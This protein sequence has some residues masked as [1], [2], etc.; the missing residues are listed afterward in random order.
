MENLVTYEGDFTDNAPGGYGKLI[1]P[2][3]CY[4]EGQITFTDA[5]FTIEGK[6]VN[7]LGGVRTGT[8]T[9]D[10]TEDMMD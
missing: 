6:I 5:K 8:F 9:Q 4:Y 3:K 2:G 7:V 10:M 1:V